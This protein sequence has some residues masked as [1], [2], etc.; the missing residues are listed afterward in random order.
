MNVIAKIKLDKKESVNKL[1]STREVSFCTILVVY[2]SQEG[3]WKGF[4]HPYGVTSQATSK[5]KALSILKGL[6]VDYRK[7]L[8]KYNFPTHLIYQKLIDA[9]DSQMFDVVLNDAIDKKGIV[10]RPHYHAE[11]YAVQS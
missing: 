4:A 5:N 2:K 8:K 7:E 1:H 11:T 6:V 10:D 3:Y 9:E